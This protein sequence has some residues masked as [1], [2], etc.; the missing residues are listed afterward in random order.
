MVASPV[1]EVGELRLRGDFSAETGENHAGLHARTLAE[2]SAAAWNVEGFTPGTQDFA[3]GGCLCG[4]S[5]RPSR[6]EYRPRRLALARRL[7]LANAL[8]MLS[9][10]GGSSPLPIG[11][12]LLSAGL[13]IVARLAGA[14]CFR[15]IGLRADGRQVLFITVQGRCALQPDSLLFHIAALLARPGI[16]FGMLLCQSRFLDRGIG[17]HGD[18]G[19]CCHCDAEKD[20]LKPDMHVTFFR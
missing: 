14:G 5:F 7:I 12:D 1:R 4:T 15:S 9:P 19:Q 8:F 6:G 16:P 20:E 10:D 18:L 2:R 11:I 17:G 13:L 3:Q